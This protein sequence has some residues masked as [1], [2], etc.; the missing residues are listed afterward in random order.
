MGKPIKVPDPVYDAAKRES[1]RRDVPL[2]VV[3]EGWKDKADKF[4]Q[5][6]GRR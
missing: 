1:E 3:V 4:E 2:G 6:E 5:V